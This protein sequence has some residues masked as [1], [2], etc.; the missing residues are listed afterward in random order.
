MVSQDKSFADLVAEA[1][2]APA[3]GTVG[4]VGTLAKS[5]EPGKFVLTL[6]DGMSVTLDTSA[7]KGHT[8]LG[9]SLGRT[10][11]QVEVEAGKVPA[12]APPLLAQGPLVTG[13]RF[14]VHKPPSHDSLSSINCLSKI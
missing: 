1:P 8:V 14:D 9:S 5:S 12:F 4:L 10:I 3:E 11:V 13:A 7:V 6:Q 2:E